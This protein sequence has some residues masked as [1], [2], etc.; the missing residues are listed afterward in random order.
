MMTL[1]RKYGA[2]LKKLDDRED[3]DPESL[4]V[5]DKYIFE[6]GQLINDIANTRRLLKEQGKKRN[7]KLMTQEQKKTSQENSNEEE[8]PEE[9]PE[10]EEHKQQENEEGTEQRQEEEDE[11]EDQDE[12]QSPNSSDPETQ[13]EDDTD[14]ERNA[15]SEEM[16]VSI[17]HS[18]T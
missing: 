14:E 1:N 8:D 7:H 2:L 9:D 11:D 10:Q 16:K 15:E 13:S 18:F 6:C 12:S 17:I 5:N 3:V 4:N